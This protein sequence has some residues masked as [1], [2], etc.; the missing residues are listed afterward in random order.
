MVKLENDQIESLEDVMDKE[1]LCR[2][3]Y[4]YIIANKEAFKEYP[5][6]YDSLYSEIQKSFDVLV[7]ILITDNVVIAELV[8]WNTIIRKDI[9]F[10]DEIQKNMYASNLKAK[11]LL[12]VLEYS[13][14]GIN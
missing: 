11:D 7:G 2:K 3:I 8:I 9:I 13:E 14:V 1:I 6:N 12:S 10:N 4:D 5:V